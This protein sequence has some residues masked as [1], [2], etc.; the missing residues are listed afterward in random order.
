[1]VKMYFG[2]NKMPYSVR[3]VEEDDYLG[4]AGSL[5]LLRKDLRE[6]FFVCNCDTILEHDLKNILNWH[7]SQKAHLTVVGCHREVVIPY[8]AIE[9]ND[10]YLKNIKERPVYDL[11]I[12]IGTYVMEPDVLDFIHPKE[13]INM[14]ELIS[15]VMKKWKVAVYPLCGG[16]FDLGQWKE[17]QDS[18]YRLE[19]GKSK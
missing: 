5:D 15:R 3:W 13:K 4:T 10:G 6:T 8:G 1:M 2:E 11:M 14:N 16:W 18:I 7:K 12:N 17:Y 9:L 19:N